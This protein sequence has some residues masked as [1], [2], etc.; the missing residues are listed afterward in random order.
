MTNF[1]FHRPPTC[2][3]VINPPTAPPSVA[4]EAQ[5]PEDAVAHVHAGREEDEAHVDEE[6]VVGRGR[7]DVVDDGGEHE[8]A[9]GEEEVDARR[10]DATLCV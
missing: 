4:H 9:V 6:P 2:T 5:L 3:N 1:L 8:D 7:G 10:R